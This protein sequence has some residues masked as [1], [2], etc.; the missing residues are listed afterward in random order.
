MFECVSEYMFLI[1]KKTPQKKQEDKKQKKLKK[2][3][4]YPW[5]IEWD[6]MIS[7]ANLICLL[8]TYLIAT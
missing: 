7:F 2:K 4:E 6:I 1:K 5:K 8:L 3:R